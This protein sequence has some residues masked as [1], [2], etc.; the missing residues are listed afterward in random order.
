MLYWGCAIRPLLLLLLVHES[1]APT[2]LVGNPTGNEMEKCPISTRLD[3][4]LDLPDI[5]PIQ[6]AISQSRVQIY[7]TLAQVP[8]PVKLRFCRPQEHWLQAY[9][10]KRCMA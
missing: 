4:L 3:N 9:L 8:E 2:P 5:T 7:A 6:E 1:A 10:L